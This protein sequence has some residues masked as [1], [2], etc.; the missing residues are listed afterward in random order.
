MNEIKSHLDDELKGVADYFSLYFE[1]MNNEIS[2][3]FYDFALDELRHAKFWLDMLEIREDPD[4]E[5]YLS[6]YEELESLVEEGR[7]ERCEY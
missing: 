6:Q 5:N 2:R 4:Y 3:D 7:G 1:Y